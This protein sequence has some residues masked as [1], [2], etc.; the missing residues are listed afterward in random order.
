[1]VNESLDLMNDDEDDY[2]GDAEV[3]DSINDY[4]ESP[5]SLNVYDD[6]KTSIFKKEEEVFEEKKEEKEI[7]KKKRKKRIRKK[8]FEKRK[9]KK[10]KNQVQKENH[11][12]KNQNRKMKKYL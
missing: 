5:Q 4:N 1:M 9:K 12:P 8:K 3:F 7:K 10:K 11:Y 2:G 6:V